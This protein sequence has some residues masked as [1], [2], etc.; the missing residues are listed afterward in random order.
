MGK[1]F[2]H[3]EEKF[4]K[5]QVSLMSLEGGNVWENNALDK[6]AFLLYSVS[7]KLDKKVKRQNCKVRRLIATKGSVRGKNPCGK[8]ED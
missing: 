2:L 8:G 4:C 1:E 7:D 5:V 3:R 6:L